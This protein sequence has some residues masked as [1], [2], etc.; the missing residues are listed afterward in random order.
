[1]LMSKT[2]VPDLTK[3]LTVLDRYGFVHQLEKTRGTLS[4]RSI[5]MQLFVTVL[6]SYGKEA[7]LIREERYVQ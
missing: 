5:W 4:W 3:N 7:F 2:F 6:I 1:M